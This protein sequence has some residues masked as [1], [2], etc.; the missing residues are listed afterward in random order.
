MNKILFA[1][2]IGIIPCFGWTQTSSNH[3]SII[4]R[5]EIKGPFI[6]KSNIYP[7]TER[8][9]WIYV[10][11]RY[12]STKPSC[13]MVVQ[14][15]LSRANG[16]RLPEVIDSL[17]YNNLMP[18]TIGIFVDHG[19]VPAGDGFYERFNRSFEYD[20]LGDRYAR[21]LLDELLPEVE[22]SYNLSHDPNDRSIAGASSGAICAFNVAWERP[23]SFRRVLS[24]IGTFVGLRGGD[25]FP[26][27][28]RKT[29]PKPL[30]VFL[31]DGSNDLNIY[32]GDWWMANQSMLSALEWAGYEVSHIWG[33][34]GHNSE[35]TSRILPDALVWL[36]KDYPKTVETHPNTVRR[37]DL[38]VTGSDWEALPVDGMEPGKL[39]VNQGGSLF[40]TSQSAVY[41][42]GSQGDASLFARLKGKAGGLSF[43]PDGLLYAADL[44]NGKIMVVD[45]KGRQREIISGVQADF[46]TAGAKGLYFSDP[47]G[48]RTGFFNWATRKVRFSEVLGVPTGVSLSAEQTF[49]NVGVANSVLGYSFKVA[50]DGSLEFGQAYHHYHV[51]Y[52]SAV[53]GVRG[54]ATD[55]GNRLYVATAMGIQV[56][57]QLGRVNFIFSMPSAENLEDVKIGGSNFDTMYIS[58]GGKLY[59]R[60]IKAKGLHGW[61]DPVKPPKPH[62]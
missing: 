4:P 26:T 37:T 62:L 44:S 15:G 5:G 54:M 22:K 6:W 60:T 28:V 48:S 49:L 56:V 61:N 53:P 23:D 32:G 19:R 10:P 2:L 51:P 45:S 58:C 38:V 35:H 14:D 25:E 52:G 33:E 11:A 43:G 36:W 31:Q 40:F 59:S 21:F 41:K 13:I 29:E 39:A 18:V 12:D 1:I 7:G 20:A 57:D 46:I 9:Y 24:S 16:W 34:G 8:N 50:G 3:A 17:V 30:R 27:L 47:S 42:V 55:A